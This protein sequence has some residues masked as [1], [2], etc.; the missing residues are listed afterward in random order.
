VCQQRSPLES[1]LPWLYSRLVNQHELVGLRELEA[2]LNQ[3]ESSMQG[4]SDSS[5]TPGEA[6]ARSDLDA[7]VA[8]VNC[9][10]RLAVP[11]GIK[12]IL[13]GH[14]QRGESGN[15]SLA[16]GLAD[17]NTA[18][19]IAQCALKQAN[20]QS[21][22]IA[23][24]QASITELFHSAEPFDN[25]P[26]FVPLAHQASLRESP[27]VPVSV[28]QEVASRPNA[29]VTH[30]RR[31]YVAYGAATLALLSFSTAIYTGTVATGDPEGRTRQAAQADAE[32]RVG[33]AHA[34][35][36]LLIA[37]AALGTL[38]ACGFIWHW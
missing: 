10:K 6:N 2:N 36:G 3:G 20:D 34:T 17:A 4:E 29:T 5:Q 28:E 24:V 25:P 16:M 35:N 26:R 7:C 9:L 22:M 30:G 31:S 32:R 18:Q 15:Y 21:H 23:A 8:E 14:I 19:S 13:I 1:D 37:G 12:S 27:V 38:A 11:T 33:Y